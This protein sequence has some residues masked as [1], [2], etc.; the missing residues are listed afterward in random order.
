[1]LYNDI[2]HI[3]ICIRSFDEIM[4]T[5]TKH[6]RLSFLHV[7]DFFNDFRRSHFIK[8][9][10]L[11]TKYDFYMDFF[12]V[13]LTKECNCDTVVLASSLFLRLTGPCILTSK[14]TEPSKS[15]LDWVGLMQLNDREA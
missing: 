11:S 4:L 15:R 5:P 12:A 10:L 3:F 2:S 7:V 14:S 9:F 8:H 1:M 6:N 13:S